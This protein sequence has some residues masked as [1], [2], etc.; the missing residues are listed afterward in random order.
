MATDYRC[1]KEE[2]SNTIQWHAVYVINAISKTLYV[3]VNQLQI[4]MPL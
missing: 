3:L 1:A 4:Y 2:Q